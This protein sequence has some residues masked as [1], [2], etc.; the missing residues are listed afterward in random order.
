MLLLEDYIDDVLYILCQKDSNLDLIES[1]LTSQSEEDLDRLVDLVTD[2]YIYLTEELA[3]I[4]GRQYAHMYAPKQDLPTDLPTVKEFLKQK[5]QQ[6]WKP[7][8]QSAYEK[9]R[10]RSTELTKKLLATGANLASRGISIG[11]QKLA[12][13]LSKASSGLS[14]IGSFTSKYGSLASTKLSNLSAKLNK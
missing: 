6:E 10:S 1:Y 3:P 9:G 4:L 14:K 12:T 11:S 5:F 8:L 7:K 2:K 13:G